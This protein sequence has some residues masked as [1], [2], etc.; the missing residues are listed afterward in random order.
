MVTAPASL[1]CDMY[2]RITF[3]RARSR[4]GV[5]AIS[6]KALPPY[7]SDE[8]YAALS[9]EQRSI[10]W[11][12]CDSIKSLNETHPPSLESPQDLE[13]VEGEGRR[14]RTGQAHRRDSRGSS[15]RGAG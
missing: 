10:W 2:V 12:R 1:P 7:L 15:D 3:D 5:T 13:G 9:D 8:E 4:A 11:W 14:H 6:P